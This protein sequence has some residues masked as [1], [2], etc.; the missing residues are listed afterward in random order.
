MASTLLRTDFFHSFQEY[1]SFMEYSYNF[2]FKP[3]DSSS[4][5]GHIG[6]SICEFS[7]ACFTEIV[8]VLYVS[9]TF[10]LYPGLFEYYVV[11]LLH[12]SENADTLIEQQPT[13]LSSEAS[14]NLWWAYSFDVSLVFQG[15]VCSAICA[16]RGLTSDLK[17][18]CDS[19]L[20]VSSM[21]VQFRG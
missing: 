19:T 9:S 14:L 17:L 21:L 10:Q 3:F 6:V 11:R 8:L 1:L 15:Y 16:S 5:W 4:L 20:W 18:M 7:S 12:S 13:S 2:C